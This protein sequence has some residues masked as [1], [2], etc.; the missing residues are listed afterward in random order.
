M[1][2]ITFQCSNCGSYLRFDGETQKWVCDYCDSTFTQQEIEQK[3]GE[4]REIDYDVKKSADV[5]LDK[6]DTIFHF[7]ENVEKNEKDNKN[8]Q[9]YHCPSCGAEV[10][11]DE[12]TAATFCVFCQNPTILPG[13]LSGSYRPSRILPFQTTKED[14]KN[15]FLKFCKGKPLLPK[16]FTG[17][18]RLEKITGMYVPFWVFNCHADFTYQSTGE[19]IFSWSDG[20]YNY[21]KTDLYRIF[22]Q[23]QVDFEDIP[24]DASEKMNDDMMDALEP[25]HLGE[26]KDFDMSYLSGFFAEKY[27]FQPKELFDRMTQRVEIGIQQAARDTASYQFVHSGNCQNQFNSE[28]QSYML[29]PVWMLVSVYG[30]EKYLFAMNGQTGKIVGKLPYSKSKT[31]LWFIGI[32]CITYLIVFLLIF[33]VGGMM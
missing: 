3:G 20:N 24:V 22:R 14:A 33:F 9:V 10:L 2:S 5:I 29:L 7:N 23:G 32:F 12:T 30:N 15:A 25:Y 27:T 11:T 16:G 26:T 4:K 21:T 6:E 13:K 18:A 31:I 19:N 28:N 8:I 1:E 17:E